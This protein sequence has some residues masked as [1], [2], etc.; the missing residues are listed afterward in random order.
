MAPV[1]MMLDVPQTPDIPGGAVPILGVMI[2]I[3]AIVFG[4]GFVMLWVYFDYR[5]KRELYQLYHAERMA[6]IEKGMELPPLPADFF[7]DTRRRA[8]PG[9]RSRRW[10]LILLFFGVATCVALRSSGAGGA[11]CWGLVPTGVGLALLI[12]SRFEA[13]KASATAASDV[14]R[15][16]GA[17]NPPSS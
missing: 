11:W 10:G 7:R 6:A 14:S 5:R 15:D 9:V 2:P 17:P 12:S 3:V 4:I 1:Q 8:A 13:E 16:S